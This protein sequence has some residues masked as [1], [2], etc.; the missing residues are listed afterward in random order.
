MPNVLLRDVPDD[1]LE[2]L[3]AAA[4]SRGQ[5]LQAYL[6]DTVHAQVTYLRRQ[7][8]LRRAAD[9]LSGRPA[10]SEEA[11]QAVLDA[12]EQAHTERA[13]QLGGDTER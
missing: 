11:R 6:L 10:V 4:G 8:A 1:V 12:I 13:A 7:A 5:S 9:R 2:E 3:K